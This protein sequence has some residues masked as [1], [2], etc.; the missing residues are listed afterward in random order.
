MG[1]APP[2]ARSHQL[3]DRLDLLAIQ[4]D[5]LLESLT[6]SNLLEAR[7]SITRE[8]HFEPRAEELQ[9]IARMASDDCAGGPRRSF[10]RRFLGTRILGDRTVKRLQEARTLDPEPMKESADLLRDLLGESRRLEAEL[11][12]ALEADPSL[13]HKDRDY[14]LKSGDA[15][16][17]SQEVLLA[18]AV[19]AYR[20][21]ELAEAAA[22]GSL[23]S[24]EP[25][26]TEAER[27]RV[28][29]F[30]AENITEESSRAGLDAVAIRTHTEGLLSA[31]NELGQPSEDDTDRRVGRDELLIR[32]QDAQTALDAVSSRIQIQQDGALVAQVDSLADE[33]RDAGRGLFS[34]KLRLV[35]ILRAPYDDTSEDNLQR[36]RGELAESAA[37][38]QAVGGGPRR[39]TEDEIYLGAL[40]DM[41]SRKEK[42][43]LEF[44]KTEKISDAK[45][46]RRR[47]A[48]MLVAAGALAV[49][50]AI[51]N[52]VVLP[53][54][55]R[56]PVEPTTQEL[57]PAA[58]AKRVEAA[59]P[60]MITHVDGWNDLDG[61]ARQAQVDKLGEI[62]KDDGF[63][64]MF[65]VNE[66]GEVA[67][68]WDH[69]TGGG[70]VEAPQ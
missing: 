42:Q 54:T 69:T 2:A 19:L 68:A 46:A 33:L 14:L 10:P 63:Q 29:A 3:R 25:R 45:R 17:C 24:A 59:G 15:L 57:R 49:T 50:S 8:L 28:A 23:E 70:L 36:L 52:F 9:T 1:V 7:R 11:E 6:E 31:W 26:L 60:M 5:A 47:M 13:N 61:N 65:V 48:V 43:D 21:A 30:A 20:L 53:G 40:K 39:E 32:M 41:R 56:A 62:V 34:I 44:R 27:N 51:V 55:K 16:S 18:N 64:M 12:Q 58:K 4:I 38:E 66:Y 35:P 67:A 37:E 22:T